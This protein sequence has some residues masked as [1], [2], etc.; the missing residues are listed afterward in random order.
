MIQVVFVFYL[1]LFVY[2]TLC[3]GKVQDLE[4]RLEMRRKK[5][6][7][8]GRDSSR[9]YLQTSS[10]TKTP[11]CFYSTNYGYK[12]PE[13]CYNEMTGLTDLPPPCITNASQ[14]AFIDG[15]FSADATF[16]TCLENIPDAGSIAS[17]Y[18]GQYNACWVYTFI[19]TLLNLV[20]VRIIES[21]YTGILTVLFVNRL[22][23]F[24]VFLSSRLQ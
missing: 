1:L 17:F 2:F 20:Q 11:E 3:N 8:N 16:Y 13:E 22:M 19:L 6:G 12:T 24:K 4:E 18:N 15:V 10:V 9:R 7:S 21:I 23:K 5:Y 14:L